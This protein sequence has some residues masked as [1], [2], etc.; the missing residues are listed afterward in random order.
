MAEAAFDYI[1]I[2]SGASG[3]LLV[4]RLVEAGMRVLLLEAGEADT[5]PRIPPPGDLVKLW[6][7]EFDWKFPTEEQSGL[8]GRSIVIN[9]GRVLGGGTSIHA[10]MYVR[11]N[12]RNFDTWSALGNDGWS[13]DEV[14]PY[15]RKVEDYEG[16]ASDLRG[17]GGPVTVRDCPDPDSRS[18][19]FQQAA[20]ELGYDGPDWDY[21]GERQENGAGPLQFTIDGEGRRVSA[22]SAFIAP[23]RDASNLTLF[24]GAEATRLLFEG[25]R[26]SGVEFRR[27]GS[28]ERARAEREVIVSAGAFLSPKLLLLSGIGPAAELEDLGL[29][30][31]ADLPGVG[32]NLQDHLQLPIAFRSKID[33][34]MPELL[35]GNVLFV[36]SSADSDTAPDLQINFTPS[37]PK[38]LSPVLDF[39]GPAMIFLP[40]LVQPRSV[41]EVRLR[42]ADPADAPLIDPHYLEH[43]ADVAALKAAVDLV[44]QLAATEA[45]AALNGGELFPGTDAEIEGFVRSQATTLWHPAG[46]CRMG[47]DDDAVVDSALRVR[48]VEGLRVV[49]ASVMPNVPSGNTQASCFMIA[50]KAAEMILDG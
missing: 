13:Y 48:G 12:R 15:F 39:G 44:R 47:R 20:V 42:S 10:M 9:Q 41:G 7:S 36:A 3:G 1:V 18:N 28:V 6:G 8:G 23:V 38:P 31:V 24:T 22:A 11:G 34:A 4:R 33:A 2:G 37:V 50:E 25:G 19:A 49:D 40:I 32:R 35:T 43:D 45:M 46:T 14:L 5:D 27:G 21:N 30:V 16:G 17:V 29:S 26:A